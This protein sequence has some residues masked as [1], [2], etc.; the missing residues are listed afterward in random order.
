LSNQRIRLYLGHDIKG[1]RSV[2]D[3]DLA[4]FLRLFGRTFPGFTVYDAT[5]YWNGKA[6]QC[7]VV[8]LVSDCAFALVGCKDLA[9]RYARDQEQDCVMITA[10]PIEDV[11]F[12]GAN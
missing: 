6:E 7:T 5:G 12:Q 1:E 3:R 2:S 9:G 4:N 8:E 10:E 11:I